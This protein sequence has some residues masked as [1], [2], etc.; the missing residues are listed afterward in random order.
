M[1]EKDSDDFLADIKASLDAERQVEYT[2]TPEETVDLRKRYPL[3]GS[4]TPED[5]KK[6]TP[7]EFFDGS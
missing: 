3:D 1:K 4:K 2:V 7:E 5:Y 6:F